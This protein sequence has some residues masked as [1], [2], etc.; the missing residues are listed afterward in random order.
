MAQL[1]FWITILLW[2]FFG[3]QILWP[4]LAMILKLTPEWVVFHQ[5]GKLL[6]MR[7]STT[8]YPVFNLFESFWYVVTGINA[9][10][11]K[12]ITW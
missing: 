9:F 10:F 7:K 3:S 5:K 4:I 1:F 2:F 12:K 11:T 8:L 6:Q